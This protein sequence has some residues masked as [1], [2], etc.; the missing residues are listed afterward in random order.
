M[1]Q[2]TKLNTSMPGSE[3]GEF[4]SLFF[5]L[6]GTANELIE[7]LESA[8][9]A[10]G[11]SRAKIGALHILLKTGEPMPLRALAERQ[12][13]VPSNIT[14]LIDR[15]ASDGLVIRTDDPQDRRSKLATLTPLGYERTMLG[16]QVVRKVQEEFE[17][18]LSAEQQTALARILAALSK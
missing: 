10:V 15:L 1:K 4:S 9:A 18:A 7:R 8:L 16:M 6:V 12:Q 2:Q 5:V 14:T 11:L 17:A 3:E 13:C